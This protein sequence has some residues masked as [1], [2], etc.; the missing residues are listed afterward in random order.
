MTAYMI[1]ESPK[2]VLLKSRRI[3]SVKAAQVKQ[4]INIG[5]D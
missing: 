3:V 4:Q 5:A 1:N 2:N